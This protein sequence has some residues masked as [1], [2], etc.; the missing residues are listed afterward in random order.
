M[1]HPPLYVAFH[2][3]HLVAFRELEKAQGYPGPRANR[4]IVAYIA[5]DDLVELL[6]EWE[7]RADDWSGEFEHGS[8]AA[9]REASRDLSLLLAKAGYLLAT[10]K[11]E[12]GDPS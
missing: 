2:G 11:A 7:E 12:E 6:N 9:L 4:K 10:E 8:R 3:D 5:G 1:K